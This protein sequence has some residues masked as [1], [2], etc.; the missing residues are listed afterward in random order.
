MIRIYSQNVWKNYMLVDSLLETQKDL[1]DIL[2]IQEPPWNFIRFAPST[3]SPGGQEVVGAPIHPEWTQVVQISQDSEQM[4]RVMCFI[5]FRLSRLHF[6]LRRD[7][8]NHR[9]IQLLS[10]FN[11]DKCQFLMNSTQMTFILQL[12][13]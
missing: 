12:I 6:A 7:I 1:Y 4:P 9:D 3:S 11:R 2:F 5:H 13:S 10:F 8:V